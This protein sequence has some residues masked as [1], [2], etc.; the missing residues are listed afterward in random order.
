[1]VQFSL[2]RPRYAPLS[3]PSNISKGFPYQIPI[4]SDAGIWYLMSVPSFELFRVDRSVL[5]FKS[6]KW[7]PRKFLIC[8]QVSESLKRFAST[9]IW[10]FVKNLWDCQFLMDSSCFCSTKALG[11]PCGVCST[12][13]LHSHSWEKICGWFSDTSARLKTLWGHKINILEPLRVWWYTFL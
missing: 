13:H 8:F 11:E 7:Q 9:K 4:E 10:F 1:M 3:S 2:E 6:P 5:R 12:T